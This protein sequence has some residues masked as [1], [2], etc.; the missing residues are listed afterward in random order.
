MIGK[1][2]GEGPRFDL[3][4]YVDDVEGALASMRAAGFPYSAM[5]RTYRGASG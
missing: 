4:V 2:M 1:S 5:R 3:F